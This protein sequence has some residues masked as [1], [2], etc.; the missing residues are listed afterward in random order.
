M[1]SRWTSPFLGVARIISKFAAVFWE[2]I[3]Y[4]NCEK[5]IKQTNAMQWCTPPAAAEFRRL[6]HTEG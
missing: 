4:W 2:N 6:A 3:Y 1:A 5:I